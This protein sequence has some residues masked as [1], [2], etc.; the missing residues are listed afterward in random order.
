MSEILKKLAPEIAAK[1]AEVTSMKTYSNEFVL[2]QLGKLTEET[3]ETF[4][5]YLR[6]NGFA[7]RTGSFHEHEL[8]LADVVITAYVIAAC[9]E[10]D[11]DERIEEKLGT[12]MTRGWKDGDVLA[13]HSSVPV[14]L[15]QATQQS[16]HQGV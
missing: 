14:E 5:A 7:R 2:S 12:V 6:A 3:G 16:D 8:E 1:V 15:L 11:L 13:N 4:G 9:E 10:F